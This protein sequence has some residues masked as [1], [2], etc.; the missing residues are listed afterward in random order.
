MVAMNKN[1]CVAYRGLRNRAIERGQYAP[2]F[3][4]YEIDLLARWLR[5]NG[6]PFCVLDPN[7]GICGKDLDLN[8][9]PEIVILDAPPKAMHAHG[10][11]IWIMGTRRR[12]VR[13]S[14]LPQEGAWVERLRMRG[15]ECSVCFLA[16]DALPDLRR[17]GYIDLVSA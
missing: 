4:F 3:K 6:V 17:L 5:D 11:A 7:Y 14:M 8:G 15:W 10:L 9:A 2:G 16:E 13:H 12:N 1:S